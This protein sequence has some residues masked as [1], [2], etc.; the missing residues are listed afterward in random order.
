MTNSTVVNL[1]ASVRQRL[2]NLSRQ[3]QE[4]FNLVLSLYAI[5]RFLYRLS[6]SPYAGQFVLKGAVL[7]SIWTGKLHRPTRDLDLLGFGDT[8]A[9]NLNEV[10]QAICRQEAPPDGMVFDASS[11][12][13]AQILEGQEYGGRRLQ[14]KATLDTARVSL[15]ID[16]GTGD[17]ITPGA[18]LTRYPTLLDFPAPELRSYP[19]ETVVAEKLHAMVVHGVV[20]SRMKDYYD[21]WLLSRLFEFDGSLLADAI[22]ATFA[23]RATPV[24]TSTPI[25]LSRRFAQD[26]Q[27]IAQW[28]AFLSRSRLDGGDESFEQVVANLEMFLGPPYRS[29]G[30]ERTF[31]A[32]WPPGGPWTPFPHVRDSDFSR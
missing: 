5:E 3:R 2:L 15:Q 17:A 32:S 24:P 20:N 29:I 14:M 27:K 28:Q 21:L 10:F 16:I 13:V 19:K 1:P 9:G 30:G 26:S 22:R 6:Q 23:R 31:T 12:R 7:F 25:A 4:D 11:I 18:R 8:S